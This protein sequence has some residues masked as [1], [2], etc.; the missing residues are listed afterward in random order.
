MPELPEVETIRRGLER[1]IVGKTITG[2]EVR[3]AKLFVGEA[4]LLVGA[5]VE[6]VRRFGKG[7]VIDLSNGYSLTAHVKMTGQFVYVGQETKHNFHPKLAAPR[8]L[9]DK[10]THLIISLVSENG[11]ASTLFYNDIRQ[12]GW[13]KVVKTTEVHDQPFFKSLGPE[14][15]STL[16]KEQFLKI[17]AASQMPIKPLLM[18]QSK[19]SGVG[20]IYAN[21]ALYEAQIDPRRSGSSLSHEEGEKLFTA[22]LA[23]LQKGIEYGGASENT[24]INVEG[25]KGS[26]QEHFLVYGKNGET[27]PRCGQTITRIVQSGRSTF[28]CPTCQT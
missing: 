23:V 9:P 25:G 22:L 17:L 6:A 10:Y 26:Y 21:D 19:L 16:T 2:V 20:N 18:D 14:P 1:T 12:F 27:C 24:Y 15:L 5:Q 4:H 13:L 3:L 11:E 7:L 28:Y 8:S